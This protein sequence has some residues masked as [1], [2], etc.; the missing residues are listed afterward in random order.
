M[1][2]IS[3][4]LDVPLLNPFNSTSSNESYYYVEDNSTNETT[5]DTKFYNDLKQPLELIIIYSIA[6]SV[7][8]L[9][10]LFGNLCVIAVVWR[11]RRMHN[12]T[13]FFI[14]NLA[15]ADVLVAVFVVPITLLTNLY[16]GKYELCLDSIS[17]HTE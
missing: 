1:E 3:A 4:V 8:F 12:V 5:S 14:V 13:N 9:F 7:V 10:A 6:Y 17:M 15:V 2:N 16:S 11:N